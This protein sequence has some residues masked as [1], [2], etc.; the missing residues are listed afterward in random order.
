MRAVN[1]IDDPDSRIASGF[2]VPRFLAK[3]AIA[4]VRSHE[5]V[6]DEFLDRNICLG[7]HVLCTLAHD[8]QLVHRGEVVQGKITGLDDQVRGEFESLGFIH[9]RHLIISITTRRR[10]RRGSHRGLQRGVPTD[11]DVQL[12][13]LGTAR[14]RRLVI[15]PPRVPIFPA[16]LSASFRNAQCSQS[17]RRYTRGKTPR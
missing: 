14:S 17:G 9:W 8:R 13:P 11:L 3:I 4:G 15:A 1:R 10:V 7:N 6:S 16:V 2:L 5:T 12:S